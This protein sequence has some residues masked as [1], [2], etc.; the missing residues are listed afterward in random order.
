MELRLDVYAEAVEGLGELTPDVRAAV[1]ALGFEEGG[2]LSADVL[3]AARTF[4]AL[5]ELDHLV[6]AML[7]LESHRV[8][9]ISHQS[10]RPRRLADTLN[11]IDYPFFRDAPVSALPAA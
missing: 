8:T 4:D 1:R 10:G 5:H 2:P 7:W 9:G 6:R 3:G 11:A